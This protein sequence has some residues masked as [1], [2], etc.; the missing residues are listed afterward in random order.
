VTLSLLQRAAALALLP[1]FPALLAA[2][3]APALRLDYPHSH[4]PL[5]TYRGTELPAA[6]L[7]NSP[8]VEQL[9]RGGKMYLSLDDAILLALENNLDIAIARYNLPISEADVERTKA[10]G[11]FRGINAGIVQNTPGG[12]VGGFGSGAPGAGAGGTTGGAGGAGS[13][14]SGLVSSTLGTGTAVNSFDPVITGSLSLEHLTQPESSLVIFGVPSLQVNTTASQVQYAQAFPTGTAISFLLENNRQAENSPF[15]FLTPALNAYYRFTVQQPLLAGFGRGPN[16]RYLR[17]ARNDRTISEIA[18][19]DQLI[20]TMTQIANIYWDLTSAY[21]DEQVK[22]RSLGFAQQTLASDRQQL[23]LQAIPAV[24]VTKAEGEVANRDEDLSIAK[25]TLQL[26]E[27]LI[28]NALTKN[29]DDARLDEIPVIP[30]EKITTNDAGASRPLQDLIDDALH[31][32]PELAESGLD[33]ANRDLSRKAARNA[34]LPSVNLEAYYAGTGLAGQNNPLSRTS[35]NVPTSFGGSLNNAFNNSSPDY[36]VGLSVAIPLRNRVAK[37]DQ[38]RSELEYRQSELRIQQLKKQIR[39]EVHNA[40][41]ALE[42]SSA[43]VLA[44]RAARDLTQKTFNIS[45]EEQKL[46]AGSNLQTLTA[47]RDLALAES[48]LAAAET[49][50]EKSRVELARAT[51]ATLDEYHVSID[52]AKT[53]V[54]AAAVRITSGAASGT[55]SGIVSGAASEI[56]SGKSKTGVR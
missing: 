32:R 52:N 48:T 29:L 1:C 2:Q 53:G 10:G 35:S 25:T 42:Q 4:N 51:G 43:R 20:A 24:E 45:R 22:E 12:G 6:S 11:T 38:Y 13:G 5:D 34:V 54:M 41:Y 55:A 7:A 56:A 15:T 44:A 31:N 30:T 36:L 47:Q 17:I 9:I 16:L 37:S 46:G 50:F 8:R 33:L 40:Q 23:A 14:A 27:S 19:K 49:T 28:K 21:Q 39:I 3:T 26:Q 18:F